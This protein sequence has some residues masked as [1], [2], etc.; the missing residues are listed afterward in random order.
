MSLNFSDF[1]CQWPYEK[2]HRQPQENGK[3]TRIVDLGFVF[4]CFEEK[5]LE[6]VVVCCFLVFAHVPGSRLPL[7]PYN[8][9]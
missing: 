9:G 4:S 7:F 3:K 6:L 2:W 8:R 5:C 1:N